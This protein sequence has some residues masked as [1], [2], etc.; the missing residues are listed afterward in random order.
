MAAAAAGVWHLLAAGEG[1]EDGPLLLPSP[2]S[3]AD[4]MGILLQGPGHQGL[5]L[6]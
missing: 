2:A 3:A 1:E 5:L 4:L 6:L